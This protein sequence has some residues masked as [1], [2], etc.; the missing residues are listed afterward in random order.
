MNNHSKSYNTDTDNES[1]PLFVSSCPG[2]ICYAEKTHP[3]IIPY[4]STVKS[5]Q[6]IL[7]IFIKKFF[8]QYILSSSSSSSSSIIVVSIQPC[9]DK[10]LEAS[11][12]DFY[13]DDIQTSEVDLVLSTTECWNLIEHIFQY[14][15]KYLDTNSIN[16]RSDDD[17]DIDTNTMDT[18][19]SNNTSNNNNDNNTS[20]NNATTN[21]NNEPL[22]SLHADDSEEVINFIHKFHNDIIS[23]S[24]PSTTTTTTTTAVILSNKTHLEYLFRCFSQNG[25][26]LVQ[27]IDSNNN[28]G[29]GGYIEYLA[30]S[31]SLTEIDNNN[32]TQLLNEQIQSSSSTSLLMPLPY[33]IGRN[34]DIAELEIISFITP[35]YTDQCT[36]TTTSSNSNG[37]TN[38]TNNTSSNTNTNGSNSGHHDIALSRNI[39]AIQPPRQQ[40]IIKFGRIYGFRNIQSILMKM[41][42]NKVDLD[43]IEIMACPSGCINGGGQIKPA[44]K[45]TINDT[46]TRI[47]RVNSIFHND[48]ITRSIHDNPLV[49]Y[50]YGNNNIESNNLN[51]NIN[52]QKITS[53]STAPSPIVTATVVDTTVVSNHNITEEGNEI[54]STS[55]MV[56]SGLSNF[57]SLSREQRRE[58]FHTRYH[59]IPKLDII[60]PLTAKW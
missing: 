60:A 40:R 21:I 24:P 8:R 18:T 54:A 49:Q 31:M 56:R 29:S 36:N 47:E 9:F 52:K 23:I 35:S 2:W 37:N 53:K 38:N 10:K 5:P 57:I 26:N 13:H 32:N 1:L 27:S 22:I 3:Q 19:D 25:Q 11:R 42:R 17:Q 7:G 39:E 41:K 58:L 16:K 55:S 45:E 59:A 12:L 34:N 15:D 50:I 46:K 4:L 44:I 51:L 28:T 6:Q 30:R 20:N 14:Q 33:K 48:K 43:L